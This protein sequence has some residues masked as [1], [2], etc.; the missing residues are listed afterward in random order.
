MSK[1]DVTSPNFRY[2]SEQAEDAQ[3]QLDDL[4]LTRWVKLMPGDLGKGQE[5]DLKEIFKD[6]EKSR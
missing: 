5:I 1:E 2:F 3:T 4:L 6:L